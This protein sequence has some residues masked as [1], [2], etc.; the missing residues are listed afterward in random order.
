[1][2]YKDSNNSFL[3]RAEVTSRIDHSNF[4]RESFGEHLLDNC[5][6]SSK[7]NLLDYL[8]KLYSL[9]F[10]SRDVHKYRYSNKNPFTLRAIIKELILCGYE[11][12][13]DFFV[14]IAIETYLAALEKR[15]DNT[16][17]YFQLL[18]KGEPCKSKYVKCPILCFLSEDPLKC[19]NNKADAFLIFK[20]RS[21][22]VFGFHKLA[23]N[24]YESILSKTKDK[25]YLSY[26]SFYYAKLLFEN[27]N[28]KK[29]I[30]ILTSLLSI[31]ENIGRNNKLVYYLLGNCYE[32]LGEI[33]DAYTYYLWSVRS[34]SYITEF[35][36]K[37]AG[38]KLYTLKKYSKKAKN[39]KIKVSYFFK[40]K[41][42]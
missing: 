4:L 12:Y 2:V 37:N 31:N 32:Q 19:N 26:V 22:H 5:S 24:F 18:R 36:F 34:N 1:M 23:C 9:E 20:A 35:Q 27:R 39:K 41:K 38:R 30:E 29:A 40:N 16:T 7:Q 8:A 6:L 11:V 28:Y 14:K 3:T 10:K 15:I 13:N 25:I 21:Y 33:N 17:A 42:R